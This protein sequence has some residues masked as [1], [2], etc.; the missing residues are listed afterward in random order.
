MMI[1]LME[2]VSG[3]TGRMNEG[4]T[5][6]RTRIKTVC[7]KFGQRTEKYESSVSES[8]RRY[9]INKMIWLNS[10]NEICVISAKFNY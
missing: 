7:Y 3:T 8:T 10:T 9:K 2:W 5:L 6:W 4:I 1:V